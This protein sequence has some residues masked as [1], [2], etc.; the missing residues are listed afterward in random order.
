MGSYLQICVPAELSHGVR[1]WTWPLQ[2]RLCFEF[3]LSHLPQ[4]AWEVLEPLRALGSPSE[5]R[6]RTV[7][8]RVMAP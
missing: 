3:W 7:E 8:G 4:E 1:G 6:M 5:N 2:V